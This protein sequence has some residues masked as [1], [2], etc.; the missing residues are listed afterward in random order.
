MPLLLFAAVLQF[1]MLPVR[2]SF[3]LTIGEKIE[4]GFG[5]ALFSRRAARRRAKKPSCRKSSGFQPDKTRAALRAMKYAAAHIKIESIRLEGMIGTGDAASTALIC[6]FTQTLSGIPGGIVSIHLNPDFSGKILRAQLTGM[7][8]A[9][10]GHI[11]TAALLGAFQLG[12]RRLKK[13]TD[14]PLKA[15]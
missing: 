3:R 14:I 8:S 1:G 4:S 2:F 12:L 6:G 7:I 10:A 5:A 15:S 13:W 11:M 9:R